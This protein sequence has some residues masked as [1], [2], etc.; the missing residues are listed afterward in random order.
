[1]KAEASC[2]GNAQ[3][4]LR[5]GTH[6]PG[7]PDLAAH[8]HMRTR[9]PSRKTRCHC[10]A[11]RKIRRRLIEADTARDL[12]VDVGGANRQLNPLLQDSK[13]QLDPLYVDG[14]CCTARRLIRRRRDKRLHLDE[15]RPSSLYGRYND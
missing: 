9:Q 7:E 12:Y 6:L 15:Q 10:N 14:I 8:D 1:M 3:L 13:E 4:C 5:D 2:L 11:E